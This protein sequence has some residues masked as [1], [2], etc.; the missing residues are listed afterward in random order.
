MPSTVVAQ[1]PAARVSV[2]TFV[3]RE[4]EDYAPQRERVFLAGCLAAVFITN[5]WA[6][7]SFPHLMRVLHCQLPKHFGASG[8]SGKNLRRYRQSLVEE[9]QH[10][11]TLAAH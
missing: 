5:G 3:V 6:A 2:G 1:A 10:Q 7:S 9:V 11:Q 8:H 4:S